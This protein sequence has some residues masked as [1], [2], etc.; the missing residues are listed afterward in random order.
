MISYGAMGSQ[1]NG[2][3]IVQQFFS[4]ETYGTST[5]Y[6][7]GPSVTGRFPYKEPLVV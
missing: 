6:I 1:C 7:T 5:F 2:N 3:D 4:A